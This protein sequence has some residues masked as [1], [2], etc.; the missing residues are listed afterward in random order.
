LEILTVD[1]LCGSGKTYQAIRHTIKK[2]YFDSQKTVI[3]QPSKDLINQSY[4]DANQ[5]NNEN[6]YGVIITR[7]DSSN[8]PYQVKSE[9]IKHLRSCHQGG[10]VLF[11]THS[12]FLTLPYF[13]GS[14]DWN[15]IIDEIPTVDQ[16][17]S[18]NV[19]ENHS[20]ITDLIESCEGDDPM[21]YRL[22]AGNEDELKKI[23]DNKSNDEVYG[24]FQKLCDHILSDH[25]EV[26][27][28]KESWER[29]IKSDTKDGIRQLS[30]FS[31]MYPSIVSGFN[32]VTIMGAMIDDSVLALDWQYGGVKF[33]P[34]PVIEKL[35]KE[36]VSSH[37][38]EH[39]TIKYFF[40]ED[41]S[42]YFRD[43]PIG[44][45]LSKMDY[46]TVQVKKE[47][48]DSS[49][50]WVANNDIPDSAMADFNNAIR[51]GNSPHGLNQYQHIH[52]SVFLSALNPS[53]AHF[54]FMQN[55]G[56]DGD[57]LRNAMVHQTTYQAVMRCSLRDKDNT[58]AKTVLVSDK[59][60]A[61]W[62]AS[63]FSGCKIGQIDGKIKIT[64]KKSGRPKK[65]NAL[66]NADRS[67][68]YRLRKKLMRHENYL[69]IGDFRDGNTATIFGSI[70]A[71]NGEG[72][73]VV[74]TNELI[75][76]LKEC[77]AHTYE[78]KHANG[79]I[80]SA[81]FDPGKSSD[82]SRG[83][84]N[85]TS[86]SGIWLDNDGGDLSWQD[87]QKIFPNLN[88][89]CMNTYSGKGR[90]RVFIPTT[91]PMSIE[92]HHHVIRYMMKQLNGYYDDATA[93]RLKSIGRKVMRHGFDVSKFT[94][95]SLFYLPCQAVETNDSF[96][97]VFG[98]IKLDP[99]LWGA[100]DLLSETKTPKPVIEYEDTRTPDLNAA[101]EAML[102]K[103]ND[104]G[105]NVIKISNAVEEYKKIPSGKGLRHNAYFKLGV[106]L[107]KFGLNDNEIQSHLTQGDYDGSRKVKGAIKSVMDSLKKVA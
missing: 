66:S 32:S 53:P 12:A 41:Y 101:V 93:N 69:N 3:V 37:R 55:K 25:W 60:S 102:K 30:M 56:I 85:I 68:K 23:A 77:H 22:V 21:Y 78:D 45:G 61:E 84:D 51:V 19:P 92:C 15:V 40:E 91:E 99:L 27:A 87:F 10:E 100:A 31:I 59:K 96:F 28:L 89:V 72:V 36:R 105:D 97:E 82:T 57:A 5:Y 81:S 63:H 48:A 54:K 13:H 95:S 42:K 1:A 107:K 74:D 58:A 73:C 50:L 62:L 104:D 64:K 65:A 2:A 80:S 9:I 49:F 103:E 7:I 29:V 83:L 11:I 88:M 90:Y 46:M 44:N 18:I 35:A 34:H 67:R 94:P 86:I 17:L 70:Y 43:T 39:L 76:Q 52:N 26:F 6:N 16:N 47:F 38:G 14:R 71:T 4:K 79:L 106:S 8:S 33:A 98:G 75:K 24:V 20:M